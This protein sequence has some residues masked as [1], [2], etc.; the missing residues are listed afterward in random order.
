MIS[1]NP[2]HYASERVLE[3]DQL[4]QLLAIYTGSPL[5]HE[6]V[7]QLMPSRDREW[8]ER[9]QQLVAEPRGYLRAGG[10]F[11]FQGLLDP[12]TLVNKSRIRGAALEIIEIRDLLLVAD[13]AAEWREIALHPP[14]QVEGKWQAILELSQILA[15]FTLLLRYFRN[16]ILPDGTLDRSEEHTSELQSLRH[17]V[18]RL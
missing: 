3:F 16:K 4:G 9:Q 2:I 13:R 14:L 15:D 6:R 7:M 11:D 1:P 18:C 12:T 17:L 8:I 10:H 5:G